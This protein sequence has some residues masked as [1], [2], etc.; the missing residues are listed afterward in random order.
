MAALRGVSRKNLFLLA[1]VVLVL[2]GNGGL[3]WR[4]LEG[5]QEKETLTRQLEDANLALERARRASNVEMVRAQLEAAKSELREVSFPKG[6]PSVELVDLLVR[7]SQEAG[8][9]LN[10]LQTLASQ[11]ER[12]GSGQYLMVSHRVEFRATPKQTREFL[13]KVEEG[14]LPTLVVDSL[15]MAPE[16]DRWRV[17][18]DILL[19]AAK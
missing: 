8:V 7:A 13:A 15:V 16:G 10:T 3:T 6:V 5:A 12:V 19:Y 4:L 14:R 9:S 1:V 18:M 17:R 11:L 2:L